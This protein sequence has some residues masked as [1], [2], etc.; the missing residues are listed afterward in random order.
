MDLKKIVKHL[1][2]DFESLTKDYEE[3]S[4]LLSRLGFTDYES[5]VYVALVALGPSSANIVAEVAQIPRTSAYKAM[6][7]LQRK[8]CVVEQKGR[9]RAYVAVDPVEVSR[10]LSADVEK[11]FAKISHV[12]DILSERGVP[13]LV[14]TIMGK[15]RVYD[16]IGEMLDKSEHTLVISTPYIPQLRSRLSR[17][18]SNAA[19]RGVQVT[20][21]TSPFVK[22][23]KGVRV[24]R[25]KG[26]I[27][28]DIISDGKTALIAAPDLSACGFTD[29]EALSRH[30]EDFLNIMAERHD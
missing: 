20:L 29:N 24:I 15:D 18:F 5:R 6:R 1:G 12:K 7:G 19:T 22:A 2:G 9:P 27:A 14:Y 28:T 4:G 21:I 30:L 11:S 10:S 26:L 8:R 23:P 17:R 3:V 16:K 13:Q 25:R